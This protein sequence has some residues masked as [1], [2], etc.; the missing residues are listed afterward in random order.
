MFQFIRSSSFTAQVMIP[1]VGILLFAVVWFLPASLVP[2]SQYGNGFYY[3]PQDG[4]IYAQ[5]QELA[6]FPLWVQVLP[7]LVL[8]VV[9]ALVLVQQDLRNL[10]MGRRSYGIGY[11][12]LFLI[13]SSGHLFLIHPAFVS[14]FLVLLGIGNLAA[15][16]KKETKFEMVFGLAFSWS[17]AILLYPPLVFTLPVIFIGLA[18]MVSPV[19]RHWVTALLGLILPVLLCLGVFYLMG[20]LDYQVSSFLDWFR[21]R[22]TWPPEFLTREPFI[23]VWFGLLLFWIITASVKYR[24]PKVLSRQLFLVNF[25]HF[26]LVLLMVI[27]VETVSVEVFWLMLCPVTYLMTF[28]A[29]ELRRNWVRNLFFMSLLASFVF[30]RI[31]GLM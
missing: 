6:R 28:W 24:N 20:E 10:L 9:T 12:F 31:R 8:A 22:T 16:F 17:L 29:L 21:F 11:L 5:W 14:G 3:L 1:F 13:A 18:V 23:A 26:F 30:F 15:L 27:L 19:W 7:T 2:G 4:W 25:F